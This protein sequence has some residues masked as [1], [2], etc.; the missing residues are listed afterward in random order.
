MVQTLLVRVL[1]E[2]LVLRKRRTQAAAVSFLEC[3]NK[4]TYR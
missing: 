2:R 3:I 4:L 1:A